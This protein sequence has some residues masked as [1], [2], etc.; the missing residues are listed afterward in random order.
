M[1]KNRWKKY[2]NG[3]VIALLLTI[4]MVISLIPFST[5]YA[6]SNTKMDIIN[7]LYIATIG[8]PDKR[9][10]V[11]KTLMGQDEFKPPYKIQTITPDNAGKIVDKIL[12]SLPQLVDEKD[13]MVN[14]LNDLNT[15]QQKDETMADLILQKYMKGILF[16]DDK[17]AERGGFDS[18]KDEIEKEY[19]SY[20]VFINCA[21]ELKDF[22][23]E[24][25]EIKFYN[26][27]YVDETGKIDIYSDLENQ[28]NNST[29]HQDIKIYYK[30]LENILPIINSDELSGER[31]N[32]IKSLDFFY[33]I[34]MQKKDNNDYISDNLGND[35][36][37]S[38]SAFTDIGS[39]LWAKPYIEELATKGIL[40]GKSEGIFAPDNNVTR[41]EFAKMLVAAFDFKDDTAKTQLS[42]VSPTEWFYPY[43]SVAEKLGIVKGDGGRFGVGE[44]I[45]RQDMAVMAYRAAKQAGCNIQSTQEAQVFADDSAIADYAKDSVTLMQQAGIINGVEGNNFAPGE[46][47]TRAQAAK[48]ICLLYR[49]KAKQ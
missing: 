16:S 39:A 40:N 29:D 24:P 6:A 47:A 14:S 2:C 17:Y 28:L 12:Q 32:L 18:L 27:I 4:I 35:D 11:F 13:N 34:D 22:Y 45:T 10:E 25:R 41:E 20:V 38:N 30:K 23:N 3:K 15:F 37:N 9:Q 44:N 46:N 49:Q 8:Q 5:I 26:F 48:I 42:D 43:V 1:L 19:Y 21:K 36:S 7:R 31:G 33:L